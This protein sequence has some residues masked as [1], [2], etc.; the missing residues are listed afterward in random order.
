MHFCELFYYPWYMYFMF[1]FA[2]NLVVNLFPL[3]KIKFI[4]ERKQQRPEAKALTVFLCARTARHIK[5]ERA[6]AP[7]AALSSSL[8]P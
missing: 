3:V 5:A 6:A 2:P 4:F 8:T 7:R 1:R